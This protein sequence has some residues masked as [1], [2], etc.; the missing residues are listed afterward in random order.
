M[1]RAFA[2]IGAIAIFTGAAFSQSADSPST[3]A[4]FEVA[5]IHASTPSIR[6]YMNGPFIRGAEYQ[7]KNASMVDLISAAYG[8]D[9]DK[10]LGGPGWLEFDRFDVQAKAPPGSTPETRKLMLQALLADRFKLV[11]HTDNKQFPAFSLAAGKNPK[12]KEADGSG[13]PGCQFRGQAP[14]APPPDA[15]AAPVRLAMILVGTCHNTSMA[16]FAEE[17]QGWVYD[18]NTANNGQTSDP[19]VLDATGLKGTWDFE[20]KFALD[21]GGGGSIGPNSVNIFDAVEKQLGLKLEPTKVALPVI[22]VD[23]VNRTPTA[24]APDVA[25]SFPPPPTEFDVAEIKPS[26]PAPAPEPGRGGRK[27]GA[28]G[29]PAIQNGR[30]NMPGYT[31]KQMIAIAWN[32]ASDDVLAGAPKWLDTDRFDVIAKA[33]DAI[34][35]PGGGRGPV[36]QD[37]YRPMLQKLLIDRFKLAVHY[38]DRPV[39]AWVLT[40]AKPKLQKADPAA[41]TKWWNGPGADGKDPRNANPALGRLVTCQNMTMAQFAAMLPSMAGGYIGTPV[42]DATGLE[43]G[44]D[45]TLSFSGAGIINGGG[46]RGSEPGPMAGGAPGSAAAADPSGGL[47]LFDAL[48]KQLG[49]KLEQQKRPMPVLV[50]DH[51]EQKPTEN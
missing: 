14:Q 39:N 26:A 43:G 5:D 38:E 34:V 3:P 7:V 1:M 10:V 25:K 23:R 22:L 19:P 36:D 50:I 21:L 48:S 11:L 13:E 8:V 31:L 24:N 17:L 49:L 16:A 20:L 27:G 42:Q 15:G 4:R 30:V 44:F 45:F 46:G 18:P 12:L 9:E 28:R 37:L 29:L 40:A 47:S 6:P 51:V 2:Y 33:P 35:T 41:R 32:L